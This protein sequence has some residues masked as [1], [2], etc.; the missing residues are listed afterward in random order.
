MRGKLEI[1]STTFPGTGITPAHAG[2][3]CLLYPYFYNRE[4]HPR[5]CGENVLKLVIHRF[6]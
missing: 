3:T 5:A 6:Y 1:I 2:K 4:D